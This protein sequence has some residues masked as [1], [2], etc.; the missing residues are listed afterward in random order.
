MPVIFLLIFSST[1]FAGVCSPHGVY[2]REQW[3]NDYKKLDGTKGSAHTRIAHCRKLNRFN[4]FSDKTNQTIKGIETN[5]K[6]W[7]H[8]DKKTIEEHLN[9]LPPW[10][11]KYKL[12]EVLR[13]DIGGNALNP[14]AAIPLTKTLIIFDH[15]FKSPSKQ[16][17]INHEIAHIAFHY[18]D[19]KLAINFA[20]LSGWVLERGK[21]P[22]PPQRLIIPDSANSVSEDFANQIEIYHSNPDRLIKF[23]PKTFHLIQELIKREETSK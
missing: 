20:A 5:I 1:L 18:I 14:A 12:T 22:A 17:I 13:G 9:N 7:N 6:K 8:A 19:P 15:F 3:I 16:D 23:N 10:L 4:Y 2:V 11:K 21:K